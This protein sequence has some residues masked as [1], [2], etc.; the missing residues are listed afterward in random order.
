MHRLIYHLSQKITRDRIDQFYPLPYAIFALYHVNLKQT[1]K[2]KS[3]L[4]IYIIEPLL[5]IPARSQIL[6]DHTQYRLRCIVTF[7]RVWLLLQFVI[8]TH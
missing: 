2:P 4:H 5:Q 8:F 1:A 7:I 6:P 3:I